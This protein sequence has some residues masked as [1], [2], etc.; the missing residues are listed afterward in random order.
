MSI[1]SLVIAPTLAKIHHDK[2]INNRQHKMENLMLMNGDSTHNTR[3]I[4]K[5]RIQTNNDVNTNNNSNIMSNADIKALLG[6]LKNEGIIVSGDYTVEIING[7]LFVD[8][9]EQD[10]NVQNKY[11]KYFEGKDDIVIRERK[12][13]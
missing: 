9:N 8:G 5:E 2:I 12:V 10:D 6:G 7:R 11:R 3:G 1:V 13:K 4:Q